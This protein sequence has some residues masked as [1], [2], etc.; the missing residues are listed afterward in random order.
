MSFGKKIKYLF[1]RYP[2]F[3]I[4]LIVFLI[5]T[6]IFSAKAIG[7]NVQKKP[8]IFSITPP[9]GSPGDI[10]VI[11]GENFGS[12]RGTSYV[13]LGGSKITASCYLN[14]NDKQI[15]IILP[16]NIED[17]LVFVK[18]AAGLSDS[19]FFVNKSSIPVVIQQA[20]K[21]ITPEI[22]SIL[23][24]TATIGSV[25]TITGS[26][27]GSERENSC[28][29]FT[30]GYEQIGLNTS[31]NTKN[32]EPSKENFISVNNE[33]FDYISWSDTE[34]Q[35]RI[36]DGAANMRGQDGRLNCIVYVDT[37][38]GA[39]PTGKFVLDNTAGKKTFSG[40]RTYSIQLSADIANS[41]AESDSLITLYVPR[42]VLSSFQTEVELTE[43][44]PE[45]LA[46]DDQGVIVH[47]RQLSQV[48][49]RKQRFIQN[50]V[51][52]NYSVTSNVKSSYIVPFVKENHPEFSKYLEA[53]S[54]VPADS[55]VIT[56]LKNKII[57]QNTN[58]Y[59]QA[60]LIYNYFKN[61]YKILNTVRTGNV[62][63][64]DL[65]LNNEGDAYDYAILY[66][67]LCRAA[68]IPAV[69][70][71]GILVEEKSGCRNH[72]WVEIYFENF[73][74]FP[75]DVALGAGLEYKPFV[76]IRD[77]FSYYFGNLDS[78]HIAFSRGWKEI[79][80]F[81][82][83]NKT[84]YR[85]RTYAFHSIWEESTSGINSYSSLWNDP[86][87]LGIY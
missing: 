39:S 54:L 63:V 74:W 43:C 11:E 20:E 16:S 30:S 84:V 29:F 81:F 47:Q 15:K 28:V 62:S 48:S 66:T 41:V 18:T 22:T 32:N 79:K 58:P 73:G 42:P 83:E 86:V 8:E 76:T 25:I 69:P 27:F 45:P 44:S 38:T 5:L 21:T 23:P 75:V 64:L 17:G 57:N 61:N 4:F 12:S 40:K 37:A 1:F 53:D 59:S 77:T 31:V 6:A 72:W 35:V 67:A 68:G 2:F 87:I 13:E 56:E 9:V 71:S 46:R 3:R 36:P 70:V 80:P 10:M 50:F 24:A 60:K 34:I 26:N 49:T 19:E 52:S 55:S 85:P 7:R 65:A 33:A 82:A 78:Q 14:W 51:I